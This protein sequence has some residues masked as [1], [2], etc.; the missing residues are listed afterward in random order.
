MLFSLISV[1]VISGCTQPPP[2]TKTRSEAS[3]YE[4]VFEELDEVLDDQSFGF[5]EKIANA[6]SLCLVRLKITSKLIKLAETGKFRRINA[7]FC[8]WT[9]DHAVFYASLQNNKC[10]LYGP[11]KASRKIVRGQSVIEIKDYDLPTSCFSSFSTNDHTATVPAMNE[12]VCFTYEPI[13]SFRGGLLPRNYLPSPGS[14]ATS[15]ENLVSTS[16]E[17]EA[18]GIPVALLSEADGFV[19]VSLHETQ[20]PWRRSWKALIFDALNKQNL[21]PKLI[22]C[23]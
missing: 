18:Y 6:P 2:E 16:I 14:E 10:G 23:P 9:D 12:S 11:D 20:N 13:D 19:K 17:L 7:K 5:A 1:S 21:Q 8:N 15:W 22:N 4:W 3:D